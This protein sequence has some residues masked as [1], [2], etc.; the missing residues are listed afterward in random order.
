MTHLFYICR[1]SFMAKFNWNSLILHQ[2]LSKFSQLIF[3]TVDDCF[4]DPLPV[5][6]Q[7]E[8]KC[9]Y[10]E[11]FTVKRLILKLETTFT[12]WLC[13]IEYTLHSDIQ[14]KFCDSYELLQSCLKW[15]V[16]P[17]ARAT[18]VTK[19]HQIICTIYSYMSIEIR[20]IICIV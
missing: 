9:T 4:L 19:F 20:G 5:F 17:P 1:N 13:D 10:V 15:L 11:R 16:Y 3:I 7:R 14:D 8:G 12:L 18:R 2:I 6:A